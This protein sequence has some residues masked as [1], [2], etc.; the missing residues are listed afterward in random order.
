[1]NTDKDNHF[2]IVCN[3]YWGIQNIGIETYNIRLIYNNLSYNYRAKEK[4]CAVFETK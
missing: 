3:R 4:G 1:M 2:W